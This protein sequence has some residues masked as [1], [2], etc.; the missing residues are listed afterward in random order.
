MKTEMK[1]MQPLN[2][3]RFASCERWGQ[4]LITLPVG[5]GRNLVSVPMNKPNLIRDEIFRGK[6]SLRQDQLKQPVLEERTHPRQNHE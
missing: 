3:S 1:T 4:M 5:V 2:K 6:Y